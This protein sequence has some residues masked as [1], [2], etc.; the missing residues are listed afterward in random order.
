M[1]CI[2]TIVVLNGVRNYFVALR[3]TGIEWLFFTELNFSSTKTPYWEEC[4]A[5]LTPE[6]CLNS[7][8]MLVGEG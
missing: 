5:L 8:R 1:R 4:M 3:S 7:R 6:P 2:C